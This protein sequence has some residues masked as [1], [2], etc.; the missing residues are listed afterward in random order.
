MN[1]VPT[2]EAAD[3]ATLAYEEKKKEK[4]RAGKFF[5]RYIHK[6]KY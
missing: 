6:R 1:L 5:N 2:R 4:D 3:K